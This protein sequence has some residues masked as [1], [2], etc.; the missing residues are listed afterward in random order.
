MLADTAPTF[1]RC[2]YLPPPDRVADRP[3]TCARVLTPLPLLASRPGVTVQ[4]LPLLV[5]WLA[6]VV[7]QGWG[8]WGSSP[9]AA[10]GGRADLRAW[11]SRRSPPG[12]RVSVNW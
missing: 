12:H 8:G 6:W 1:R 7:W 5:A 4:V 11:R 9:R 10:R 2:P 3:C